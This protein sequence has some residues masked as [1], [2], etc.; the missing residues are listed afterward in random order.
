[1][2]KANVAR[3]PINSLENGVS[4]QAA[5]N[6]LPSQGQS[7]I[8]AISDLVRGVIKRPPLLHSAQVKSES[9][10]NS[11]HFHTIHR[12]NEEQYLVILYD[13]DLEI[14][15]VQTGLPV[16]V[17]FPD[18]K[19]YLDTDN[20][21][22]DF[23]ICT[24][25]DTS[26]IVNRSVT[27]AM[28][29]TE[30]METQAL[31]AIV[32]IKRGV[33]GHTYTVELNSTK[34]TVT[35]PVPVAGEPDNCSTEEIANQ[36]KGQ[37]QASG[38]SCAQTGSVLRIT[39][40]SGDFRFKAYDS[41]G[42]QALVGF[43]G[44]IQKFEDLPAQCFDGVRVKVTGNDS[45][46]YNDY[47]VEFDTNADYESGFWKE[48]RGWNQNNKFDNSTMPHQLLRETDG[49]FTFQQAGWEERKVGDDDTV[50]KPP[51]VGNKINDIYFHLNRLGVVSRDGKILSRD[52]DYEN[53]WPKKAFQVLDDDP[54]ILF[55]TGKQVSDIR[56]AEPFNKSLLVFCDQ[57]QF[58]LTSDGP[59]T[60]KTAKLVETTTYAAS[61]LA[62]P[63]HAGNNVF[64]ISPNGDYSAIRE[65]YVSDESTTNQAADITAHVQ[66]YIPKG[67]TQLIAHPNDNMLLAISEENPNRI[68][69]YKYIWI[70][71]EKGQSSW[72]YFEFAEEDKILHIAMIDD[73]VYLLIE[74]DTGVYI[75]YMTLFSEILPEGLDFDIHL[76]RRV[77]LTGSYNSETNTTTWTLPYTF[78]TD[79][80][81][82]TVILGG[83]FTGKAGKTIS[84]ERPTNTTFTITGDYTAGSV[85]AGI[86]YPMIYEFS[87]Q[88][89]RDT[90]VDGSPALTGGRT[91]IIKMSVD[92]ANSGTFEAQV[93]IRDTTRVTEKTGIIGSSELRIGKPYLN[94]GT[95]NFNVNAENK[96]VSIKLV[97]ENHY[98]VSYQKAEWRGFRSI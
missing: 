82:L 95:F 48:A 13:G 59:L 7:Q 37:I 61:S 94:T 47:Y 58:Q 72:S 51:F 22:T 55:T 96:N 12:D 97:S 35:A 75:E 46:D 49:T 33:R 85:Y 34:I 5:I 11:A 3:V 8:N 79:D 93:P 31:E 86:V 10:Y 54:I 45:N 39:Y 90:S 41:F 20:P 19:S 50:E 21:T 27:V 43:K 28:D 25:A 76:D 88:Y 9:I 66:N 18:G 70:G 83:A 67:V 60:P 1:M 17:T 23:A 57:H 68:Y 38:F 2:P 87:P 65:Y 29:S 32:F 52:N 42:N 62:R 64:F 26:W 69:I 16:T 84:V 80:D 53:F 15:D 63:T 78:A 74:R 81:R 30:S 40:S 36:L 98:P 44:S 89:V 91:Q 73:K 14:Y 56:F 6:R 77:E 92:Y 4:Q 71:D 24:I